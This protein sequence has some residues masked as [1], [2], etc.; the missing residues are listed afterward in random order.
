MAVKEFK[1]T[2]EENRITI[3]PPVSEQKKYSAR[4]IGFLAA[5]FGLALCFSLPLLRLLHLAVSDDL[6]S[7]IPLIPLV[8]LY[9]LWL[10]HKNLPNRF[11]T[12][13]EPSLLLV[14][15]GF[16]VVTVHWLISRNV[17]LSNEDDLAFD[18][19]ALLLLF[20]G[21]C[22]IF[23]GKKV[24]GAA[25]FPIALLIFM[26]PL[27]AFL[28]N[29]IETFLQYG[30]ALCAD[31][32]FQFSNVPIFRTGLDFH[33]PNCTLQVAP[34]CSGIHSTLVL[35]ITSLIGGWLFLRS[36]WKRVILLLAVVPLAL[37]RNGFRIF[38]IGRLCAAYGPQMLDTPIHRHG[39]P[40]FFVLSLIPFSLLLLFLR[41][42]ELNNSDSP[43]K[44]LL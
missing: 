42:T 20:T 37:V 19:F 21:I 41:K 7:D 33:L 17:S 24:V 13:L 9:L 4:F 8:S 5:T 29:K 14:G 31:G 18:I 38:I 28:R 40:L 6:Y 26:V 10:R 35:A 34:E 12:T 39:G 23:F 22:F 11:E 32:F 1:L 15:T 25:A 44:K 16:L 3:G 36:P 30:S 43:A 2:G 27:P